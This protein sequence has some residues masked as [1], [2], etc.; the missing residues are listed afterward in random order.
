[1]RIAARS[2]REFGPVATGV[3]DAQRGHSAGTIREF[4]AARQGMVGSAV[5]RDFGFRMKAWRQDVT[6]R[7]H[8]ITPLRFDAAGRVNCHRDYRDARKDATRNCR[9]LD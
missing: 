2:A 3:F 9:W 6:R 4:L 5:P 8:G 7:M 1:M